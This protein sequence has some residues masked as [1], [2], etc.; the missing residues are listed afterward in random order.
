MVRERSLAARH[1]DVSKHRASASRALAAGARAAWCHHNEKKGAEH[2]YRDR[3]R[4]HSSKHAGAHG[5]QYEQQRHA[6]RRLARIIA[7]GDALL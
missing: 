4:Y 7:N 5:W 6:A 3:N 2:D 1:R